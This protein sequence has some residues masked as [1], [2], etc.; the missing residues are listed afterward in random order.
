MPTNYKRQNFQCI[1]NCPRVIELS[2]SFQEAKSWRSYKGILTIECYAGIEMMNRI[3]VDS[4]AF[5]TCFESIE[6]FADYSPATIACLTLLTTR[7]YLYL[8]LE[9]F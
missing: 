9:Q 1:H 7:L 6:S 4:G 3:L 2:Q 8:E 5:R